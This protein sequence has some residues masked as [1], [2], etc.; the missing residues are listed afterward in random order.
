[1]GFNTHFSF[2][3]VLLLPGLACQ[4]AMPEPNDQEEELH[5]YALGKRNDIGYY[6]NTKPAEPV[7]RPRFS[8]ADILG[9]VKY[10]YRVDLSRPFG[11]PSEA[12]IPRCRSKAEE[13]RLTKLIPNTDSNIYTTQI[14]SR[15]YAVKLG[16]NPKR[17]AN[18]L[19]IQVHV[20]G[21]IGH[22]W[23]V[24]TEK[25]P[26]DVPRPYVSRP[27]SQIVMR[28]RFGWGTVSAG[29]MMEYIPPLHIHTTKALMNIFLDPILRKLLHHEPDLANVRLHV[30]MGKMA[31]EHEAR[32]AKLLSRPVYFDQ[33]CRGAK[34]DM[35]TWVSMM[36]ATLAI[37]HWAC[38][39]DAR[40]VQFRLAPKKGS[41]IMLWITNFGDCRPFEPTALA[42]T[43][44][45]HA[46]IVN[47]TWPRPLFVFALDPESDTGKAVRQQWSRFNNV[48]LAASDSILREVKPKVAG[49]GLPALF[50]NKVKLAWRQQGSRL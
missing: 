14:G 15:T 7:R 16:D 11:G 19:Q 20:Y 30:R 31:P 27:E 47:S 6:I 18:E 28:R 5:E 23:D 42:I 4:A 39:I 49:L 34:D 10:N 21:N 48:Y 8:I 46:L 12:W 24:A 22:F 1:M 40:G 9:H 25:T 17:M 13:H 36:G 44:L 32:S 3:S 43:S 38:N 29:F 37:L 50:I 26:E 41:D 35:D 33:L 2:D 45:A